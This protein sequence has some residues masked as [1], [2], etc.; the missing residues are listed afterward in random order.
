MN[1]EPAKNGAA[2]RR[3]RLRSGLPGAYLAAHRTCRCTD[4]SSSSLPG[5]GKRCGN[6]RCGNLE[7]LDVDAVEKIGTHEQITGRLFFRLTRHCGGDREMEFKPEI[8]GGESDL[9]HAGLAD[10]FQH[11]GASPGNACGHSQPAA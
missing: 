8:T 11:D 10:C 3:N 9:S 6:P 5:L 7:H 2:R 1:W 4:R